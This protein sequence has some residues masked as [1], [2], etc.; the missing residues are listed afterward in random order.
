MLNEWTAGQLWSNLVINKG[1]ILFNP[2]SV[3]DRLSKDDYGL[4]SKT[5]HDMKNIDHVVDLLEK[6][7]EQ[8]PKGQKWAKKVQRGDNVQ[9]VPLT[10]GTDTEHAVA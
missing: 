8:A 1:R 10:Q 4:Y 7:Q 3:S 2:Q 9:T 6:F 5:Y